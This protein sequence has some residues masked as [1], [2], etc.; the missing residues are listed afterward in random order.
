MDRAAFHRKQHL[1]M[2]AAEEVERVAYHWHQQHQ[3]KE[4]TLAFLASSSLADMVDFQTTCGHDSVRGET[5]IDF[6][7]VATEVAVAVVDRDTPEVV[8]VESHWY[9][10][11]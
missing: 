11:C 5:V 9:N 3:E 10:C 8:A 7:A 6:E 4:G 2:W 1:E